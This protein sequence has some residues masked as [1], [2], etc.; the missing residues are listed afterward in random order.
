MED[1]VGGSDDAEVG[2][3][4]PELPAREGL[5]FD[6]TEVETWSMEL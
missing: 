2:F 4:E 6:A 1:A 5:A 3:E